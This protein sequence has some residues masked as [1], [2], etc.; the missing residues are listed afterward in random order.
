MRGFGVVV[1][2]AAVIVMGGWLYAEASN[3]AG[4]PA[5]PE[6]AVALS[7]TSGKSVQTNSYDALVVAMDDW[8]QTANSKTQSKKNKNKSKSF[9]D[10]LW[11]YFYYYNLFYNNYHGDHTGYNYYYPYYFNYYWFFT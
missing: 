7:T 3:T 5:L 2:V 10:Y 8:E 1:V 4:A 6:R 11:A 9:D